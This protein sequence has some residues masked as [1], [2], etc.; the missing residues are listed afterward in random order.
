MG[1]PGRPVARGCGRVLARLVLFAAVIGGVMAMHS[2][3][4]LTA[5]DGG[6]PIEPT[7]AAL[8]TPVGT[9]ITQIDAGAP[10]TDPA[11][12]D[13]GCPGGCH[14]KHPP[15]GPAHGFDYASVCVAVLSGV[16][17]LIVVVLP[18]RLLGSARRSS[19]T[20]PG[21]AGPAMEALTRPRTPSLAQLSVLRI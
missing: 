20:G 2:L 8:S 7:R 9:T 6:D 12:A 21:H 10:I 18:G 13:P 3:G 19:R 15:S 11:A 1:T 17:A 14:H 16:L 5:H 4:H